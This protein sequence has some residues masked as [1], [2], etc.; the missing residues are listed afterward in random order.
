[1]KKIVG[2]KGDVLNKKGQKSRKEK[3]NPVRRAGYYEDDLP[4]T[5]MLLL[6]VI[7][8]VDSPPFLADSSIRAQRSRE[9]EEE[10]RMRV[11]LR[12][13]PLEKSKEMGGVKS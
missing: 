10:E 11:V 2:G 13:D 7:C 9:A 1:M 6:A 8:S 5:M 4:L 3:N 12:R